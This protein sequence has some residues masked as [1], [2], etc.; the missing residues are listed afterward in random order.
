MVVVEL[1]NAQGI[2]LVGN[3]LDCGYENIHIGMPLEVVFEDH[4]DEGATPP[5]WERADK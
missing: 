2:H 5:L 1:S 3:P 4:H